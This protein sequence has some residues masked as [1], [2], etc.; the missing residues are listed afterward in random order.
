MAAPARIS[1]LARRLS[2]SSIRQGQLVKT[3]IQVYGV[4][5]RYATA[6]YSAATKEKQLDQVDK[7]LND[8]QSLLKKDVK[9]ADFVGNPIVTKQEKSGVLTNWMK[10]NKCSKVTTNFVS[11]LAE[12][13]RVKQLNEIF[14]AWNEIMG[15]HRG[16]VVCTI[17]TAKPLDAAGQKSIESAMTGFAKKNQVLKLSLK[18]DP[19]I[20][21][22]MVVEVGDKYIDMSTASKVKTMTNLLKENM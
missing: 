16:E 13:N 17:T 5:G 14:S 4:G 22:G 6:L 7:D 9:L 15:A 1:V 11:M 18:V 10:T 21:S 8:F 3:P 2:T 19:S 20:I 12:N